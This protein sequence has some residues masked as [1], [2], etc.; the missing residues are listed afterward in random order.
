M[1]HF[2]NIFYLNKLAVRLKKIKIL[3]VNYFMAK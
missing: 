2:G 3:K 1:L